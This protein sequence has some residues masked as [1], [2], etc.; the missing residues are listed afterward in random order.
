[1]TRAYMCSYVYEILGILIEYR[2][3][4]YIDH[5][6]HVQYTIFFGFIKGVSFHETKQK[7]IADI[8]YCN[9]KI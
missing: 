3:V 7:N 1:M 9:L 4:F 6:L 2:Y 8:I 5:N